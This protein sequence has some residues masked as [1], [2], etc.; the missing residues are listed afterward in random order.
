M[1]QSRQ[2][3]SEALKLEQPEGLIGLKKM[4]KIISAC[5]VGKDGRYF[6]HDGSI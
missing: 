2:T 3:D 6:R 5:F 1:Y 4:Q